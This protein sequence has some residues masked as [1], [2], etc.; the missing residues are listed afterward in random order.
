MEANR[1]NP[2]RVAINGFGRIGRNFIRAAY[3]RS[4]FEIV[5]IND[6]FDIKTL[7]HLLKYDSVLGSFPGQVTAESSAIAVDG[8]PIK[9]FAERDPASL[10]W[11]DLNVDVV[12]EATG[13]FRQREGAAKHLEAGAKKVV[14]TAPATNPDVTLVLGVN[15][16]KYDP[17]N[18]HIISNASCTTNCL[19]PIAKVLLDNFGIEK[20][21]M[22]TVHAYTSDQRLLD[23]GHSDLRRARA[24]A[25]NMIPTTTGAARALSLVIPE[26][27]GKM[28]GISIRV[29]TPNVSLVDL[30]VVLG[31]STTADEINSKFEEAAK[32]SLKGIIE[33]QHEELVSIDFTSN[34]HSA[35]VDA[36][37]TSVIQ[38]NLAKVLAW[39][40]NEFG[41]S[42]RLVELIEMIGQTM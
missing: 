4:T 36:P 6:L 12:I 40:D 35:I 7:A 28:D 18:H 23:F 25:L 19:A 1:L 39:Y 11:S 34:P 33:Y 27:E 16:Q 9:A 10:P 20:G 26:L 8:N 30:S 29:P 13:I 42:N 32:S 22:T 21:L 37:S 2:V 5:A 41:F 24:A 17:N 38:G 14:I 15:H 3:G 31:Q